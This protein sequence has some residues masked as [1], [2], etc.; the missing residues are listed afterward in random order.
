ML[1]AVLDPAES[2]AL[3]AADPNPRRAFYHQ[4]G[5]VP[6]GT[7]QVE[8]GMREIRMVRDGQ[9]SRTSRAPAMCARRLGN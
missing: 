1:E 3:W 2:A 9:H 6:D 5:F 7:A 4:R 8:N